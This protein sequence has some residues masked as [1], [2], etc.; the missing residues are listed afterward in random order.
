MPY[1]TFDAS[2]GA[3]VLGVGTDR[4]FERLAALVGRP[5]WAADERYRA[6][7]DRVRHRVALEAELSE[8]FRRETRESWVSSCRAA[9]I[10]AGPVR[11]PLEALR[12]ETARALEAV[13]AAGGVS[14]VASPIRVAG[15][16]RRLEFPPAL[17]ADGER[18]RREFDLPG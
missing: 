2:D 5:E 13:V 11:G 8:I 4:Q 12:S 10:P 6:N 3:F 7:A 1:R 17:D 15:A 14:F 9:G 16:P 18:L